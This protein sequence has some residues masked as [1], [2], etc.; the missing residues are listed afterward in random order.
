MEARH[1]KLLRSFTVE[2]RLL[3]ALEMCLLSRALMRTGIRD[4][5]PEWSEAEVARELYRRAFSP[6]PLPDWVK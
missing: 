1:I 4:R 5:H 2:E 3:Q 6:S